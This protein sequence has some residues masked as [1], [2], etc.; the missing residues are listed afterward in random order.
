MITNS[1][2]PKTS[3][4]NP[5]DTPSRHDASAA[6][7]CR[8]M[9][10]KADSANRSNVYDSTAHSTV[11]QC[12]DDFHNGM[13]TFPTLRRHGVV[14]DNTRF[15][16]PIWQGAPHELIPHKELIRLFRFAMDARQPRRVTFEDDNW[17][18]FGTHVEQHGRHRCLCNKHRYPVFHCNLRHFCNLLYLKGFGP[19]Q[20]MARFRQSSWFLQRHLHQ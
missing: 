18:A 15:Y 6:C 10:C 20:S 13:R 12:S 4:G 2:K 17:C 11:A 7:T 9:R 14:D 16:M 19:R 8:Q 1:G 3:V 5:G